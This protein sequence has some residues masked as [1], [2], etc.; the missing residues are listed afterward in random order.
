MK[1][2]TDSGNGFFVWRKPVTAIENIQPTV[3]RTAALNR[4]CYNE[5]NQ[6]M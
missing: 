1:V 3:F 5:V 6:S 4:N 2:V